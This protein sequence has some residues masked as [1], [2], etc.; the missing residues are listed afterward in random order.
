MALQQI[1]QGI[2]GRQYTREQAGQVA[3]YLSRWNNQQFYDQ[4]E[5]FD[6]IPPFAPLPTM[7]TPAGPTMT[8]AGPSKA[9][10]MLNIGSAILGGVNAGIGMHNQLNQMKLPT[11]GGN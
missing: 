8:G 4:Q 7:V 3:Q 6:P 9:A 2:R 11:P 10:G 1:N 5:V